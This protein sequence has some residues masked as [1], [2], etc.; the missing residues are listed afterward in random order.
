MTQIDGRGFAAALREGFP[1]VEVEASTVRSL[2]EQLAQTLGQVRHL[3]R[4][5][6][7]S[8]SPAGGD[9]NLWCGLVCCQQAHE[10][11]GNSP[12]HGREKKDIYA[13]IIKPGLRPVWIGLSWTAMALAGARIMQHGLAKFLP[14][15]YYDPAALVVP[16]AILF[17]SP[18]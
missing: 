9:R 12:C 15:E 4:I 2:I 17:V 6:R 10:R 13:A 1:G 8:R 11:D 16:A 5:P 7:S 14:L 3:D 18:C